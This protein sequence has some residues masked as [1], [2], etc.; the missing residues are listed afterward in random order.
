MVH[1]KLNVI[2]A[3][4]NVV[5]TNPNVAR[6]KPYVVYANGNVICTELN[7][8]RAIVN[9][10]PGKGAEQRTLAGAEGRKVNM[11]QMKV[12]KKEAPPT[13]ID[14]TSPF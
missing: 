3:E 9:V 1:T 6:T 5:R 13:I 10:K 7:V 12:G 14:R 8:A 4:P 11:K 2:H